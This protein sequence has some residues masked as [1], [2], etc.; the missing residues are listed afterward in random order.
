MDGRLIN[1]ETEDTAEDADGKEI[2]ASTTFTASES[3]NG[4]VVVTFSF[5]AGEGFGG[6]TFVAYEQL[7]NPGTDKIYA[8]HEDPDDEDQTVYIPAVSTTAKD[9]VTGE[10]FSAPAEEVSVTDTVTYNNLIPGREYTLKGTLMLKDG[11]TAVASQE[12][13]FTPAEADGTEELVFTFDASSLE[14]KDVVAF[15]ELFLEGH[16]VAEHKDIEDEDQTV[17]FPGGYTTA[18]DSETKTQNSMAD[19]SS[20]IADEFNYTNL[21]P[22]ETYRITGKVM[23]K[24]T[25]KEIES[26]MVD[27]DGGEIE[28]GYVEFTPSEKDGSIILYFKIDASELAG[29]DAV[30][31]ENVTQDGKSVIVHEDLNDEKQTVHYPDG[32]TRAIDTKTGGKSILAEENALIEDT[33]DYTNL[34]P[35]DTYRITGSVM[36]KETDKEIESVMADKDGNPVEGGAFSFTPSEKDGSV[37]LYFLIDA[38]VLENKTV[39]VF[40][41]VSVNGEYI[42]IH[43]DIDDDAQ[44]AY[45]PEGRTNAKDSETG[46]QLSLADKEVTVIDAFTYSNLVPGTE[47]TITGEE[48]TFTPSAKDGEIEISFTFDGSALAGTDVVVFERAYHNG[49]PVII[50]ENIDDASQTVHIPDGHTTAVDK[51]NGSHTASAGKTVTVKDKFV[52]QNL[53]AGK[54]YTITGKVMDKATGKEV[55]STMT[56]AKGKALEKLTFTAEK[57]NGSVYIYFK[58]D[59]ASL[60]GK[61]LVAFERLQ[62]EGRDIIIHENLDDEDQ[63][64][65]VPNGRTTALDSETNSH[66]SNADEKVTI[67][68]EFFYENLIPGK[69]Y[70]V[71]GRLMD[72]ATG[73][74]LIADGKEVTGTTEFVPKKADGSV[75]ITFTFNGKALAGKTT[76]AFE[77]LY[78]DGKQVIVH[79]DLKDEEQ[80]HSLILSANYQYM[81]NRHWS[82]G[83]T[84]SMGRWRQYMRYIDSGEIADKKGDSFLTAMFSTR[85]YWRTKNWVRTY[86]G[87]SFGVGYGWEEK[88]DPWPD[89][90]KITPSWQLTMLGIEVGKGRIIG[91]GEFGFGMTGWLVGG[92]GYRF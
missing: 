62:Y 25:G 88:Y 63:T 64:V 22:G 3:G 47:Y 1:K 28:G 79:E 82:L 44:T 90:H 78:H 13:T 37:K 86:S 39:V 23:S 74:A 36:S 75:I 6:T 72:K 32:S 59:A 34:V 49:S 67:R 70:T 27:E 68:D 16:S 89:E 20:V 21:V 31:F 29:K 18:A 15:E 57:E 5:K 66:V 26:V 87:I 46:V 65:H 85:Y 92:I 12:K 38:S 24:E 60:Q 35:G 80:K 9:N 69:K 55:K 4:S 8:I 76:V 91:F 42:I 81:M 73:R 77:T 7:K 43:E 41:R 58:V 71:K 14:G 33:F 84:I 40:E 50:H 2:T 45:I 83:G 17:H 51:E 54:E 30:V 52:Y 56:D 48:V 61:N 19:E 11:N 53:I 10:H